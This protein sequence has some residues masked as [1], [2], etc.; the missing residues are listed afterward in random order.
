[1]ATITITIT[2]TVSMTIGWKGIGVICLGNMTTTTM[3][4]LMLIILIPLVKYVT[5]KQLRQLVRGRNHES[6]EGSMTILLENTNDLRDDDDNDDDEDFLPKDDTEYF[7]N[8][9]LRLTNKTHKNGKK[10]IILI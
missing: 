10:K 9:I 3:V 7:Y 4:V 5:E 8:R 6:T 1:M 2:I